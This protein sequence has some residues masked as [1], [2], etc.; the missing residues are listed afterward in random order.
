MP[1]CQRGNRLIALLLPW[2]RNADRLVVG[3]VEF[4]P[5]ADALRSLPSDQADALRRYAGMYLSD[6]TVSNAIT[7]VRRLFAAR[8]A[9]ESAVEEALAAMHEPHHLEPLVALVA[10]RAE[11]D[12]AFHAV[13]CLMFAT[14]IENGAWY[15]NSMTFR[16]AGYDLTM[17]AGSLTE[18]RPRMHGRVMDGLDVE[19]H[20]FVRPAHAEDYHRNANLE[21]ASALLRAL[22][23]PKGRY[24]SD[25]LAALRLAMNDSPDVTQALQQSLFSKAA[26]LVIWKR[27]LRRDSMS[28]L[29]PRVEALLASFFRGRR[30]YGSKQRLRGSSW[31]RKAWIAVRSERNNFW[32]PR[33]QKNRAKFSQQQLVT[34]IMIALRTVY[35]L[36]LT[37]LAEIGTLRP[38]S[39]LRADVPAIAEWI[40]SL[41]PA[42]ERG[43]RLPTLLSSGPDDRRQWALD[44]VAWNEAAREANNWWRFRAEERM[45]AG[46][47]KTLVKLKKRR[48]KH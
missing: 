1:L 29:R 17:G 28:V 18:I 36:I 3:D 19:S 10:D 30:R 45:Q 33:R 4:L 39:E 15:A 5:Y 23:M 2:V 37:R 46:I 16:A 22:S 27:G 9:G 26:T 6:S 31:V 7:Q 40:A 38:D 25:A 44:S 42:L 43:L 14:V 48:R 35:A 13:D 32:H 20:F 34:P 24:L 47:S 11:L 41:G 12:H 8:N 21:F